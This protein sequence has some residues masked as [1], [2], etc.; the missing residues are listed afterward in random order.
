[1]GTGH[2]VLFLS[3]HQQPLLVLL[4]KQHELHLIILEG[5]VAPLLSRLS[6]GDVVD[7]RVVAGI[8]L[9]AAV[10]TLL[11]HRRSL[12]ASIYR[13][14]Q[15]SVI[16]RISLLLEQILGIYLYG[17]LLHV[18]S[19]LSKLIEAVSRHACGIHCAW[20]R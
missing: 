14:G 4:F 18:L 10:Q 19:L 3:R 5:V 12:K 9:V 2:A 1:M 6:I 13:L 7:S 20:E 11:V 15:H 16:Q 17:F 8:D